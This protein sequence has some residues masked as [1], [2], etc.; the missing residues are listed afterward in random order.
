MRPRRVLPDSAAVTSAGRAGAATRLIALALLA[1]AVT[2]RAADTIAAPA[3]RT[4]SDNTVVLNFVNADLE[5]VVRAIGQFTGRTF[6]IDP[7]VKGTLTLVTERPVT[8]E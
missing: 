4:A 7:R 1:S 2:A 6:V 8:R 5:A 3:K